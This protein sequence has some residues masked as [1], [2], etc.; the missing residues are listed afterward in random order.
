MGRV[1]R[2]GRGRMG[3]V[4]DEDAMPNIRGDLLESERLEARPAEEGS[5][6]GCVFAE[7]FYC[8][9]ISLSIP[10]TLSS[11]SIVVITTV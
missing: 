6:R 11:I 8:F 1:V 5:V 3:E 10:F 2:R 4:Y 7:G 9:L